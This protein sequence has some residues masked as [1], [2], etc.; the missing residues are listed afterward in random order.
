MNVLVNIDATGAEMR[1]HFFT[2]RHLMLGIV[3]SIVDDDVDAIAV[4]L[5]IVVLYRETR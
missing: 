5:A 2:G 1:Q 3:A 4:Y